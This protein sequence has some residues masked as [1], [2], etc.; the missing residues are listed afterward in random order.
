MIGIRSRRYDEK[1]N[2]WIDSQYNYAIKLI[3][4]FKIFVF[5]AHTAWVWIRIVALAGTVVASRAAEYQCV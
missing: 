4:L 1:T 3:F 2:G 5:F